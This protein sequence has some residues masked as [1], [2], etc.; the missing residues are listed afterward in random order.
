MGKSVHQ[1]GLDAKA[2]RTETSAG[3]RDEKTTDK[4]RTKFADSEQQNRHQKAVNRKRGGMRGGEWGGAG[5]AY[6]KMWRCGERTSG[7]RCIREVN[8]KRKCNN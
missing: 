8:F 5:G 7:L 2:A 3:E 6:G 4:R 1:S